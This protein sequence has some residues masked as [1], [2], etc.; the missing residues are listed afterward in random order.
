MLERFKVASSDEVRVQY[1]HLRD[2]VTAIF[3]RL[4]V[5]PEDARMAGE[6]LAMTDLRGIETHG[7]SNM[8]RRYV[9]WY[10]DGTLNPTPRWRVLSETP[11]AAVVDSDGGLGLIHGARAMQV[12]ID[13]ARTAGVGV[14]TMQNSG[15]LGAA[16]HHALLAAHEHMVGLALSASP[17]QVLPTFGAEPRLG[18]NPIAFAAP[19]RS[20]PLLCFDVATSAIASN[21]LGLAKRVGSKLE[22]GW[23][24]GP[25]GAPIVEPVDPP[26][27]GQFFLLPLGGTRDQGS[28]KGY[29]FALMVEVLATMLAGAVPTMIQ[30]GPYRRFNHHLAAYNVAAFTDLDQFLDGM[31]AMLQTLRATKPAPG[32][33][34]VIYPGLLEFEDEQERLE[35][36]IPLHQEVI[37]WFDA[38]TDDMSLPRLVRS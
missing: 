38:T 34:R 11:A 17:S 13:K 20:E 31:D 33:E 3:E 29:G 6:A 10:R 36:G 9:E 28:H 32:E 22:P 27:P 25:D 7:V 14:V 1:E 12:A 35:R 21:K 26:E 37:D 23:I 24:A 2:T 4:G 18:T 8:L 16:G 15:H 19:T 5:S 30:S